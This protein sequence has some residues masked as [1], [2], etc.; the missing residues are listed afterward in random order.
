ML[1]SHV[2]DGSKPAEDPK[3]TGPQS[4]LNSL[5]LRWQRAGK[6][7]SLVREHTTMGPSTCFV[8]WPFLGTGV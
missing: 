8:G 1:R 7:E 4:F 6:V 2:A 3:R 5:S